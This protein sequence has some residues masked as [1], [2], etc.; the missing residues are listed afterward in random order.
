M[1]F[2]RMYRLSGLISACSGDWAKKYSGCW[3]MYW[4]SGLDD[5]TTI[6]SDTLPRRPA[7]PACCQVEAMVPG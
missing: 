4:S 1:W 3:M 7:R 2:R 6:S 5:A